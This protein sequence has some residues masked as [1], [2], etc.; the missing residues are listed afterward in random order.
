MISITISLDAIFT[1]GRGSLFYSKFSF[2]DGTKRIKSTALTNKYLQSEF[3]VFT[4]WQ[5]NVYKTI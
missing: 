5:Y 2:G 3:L 1:D 4:V